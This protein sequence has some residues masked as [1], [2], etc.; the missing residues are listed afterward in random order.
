MADDTIVESESSEE[1]QDESESE[2]EPVES[3]SEEE[4]PVESESEEEPPVESESE[5]EPPAESESE[6]EPPVDEESEEEPPA[7]SESEEEPPVE[8]ESEEEPPVDDLCTGVIPDSCMAF[9]CD[10]ILSI[11]EYTELRVTEHNI[12]RRLHENTPDVSNNLDIACQA[13]V[14]ANHMA[15]NN[16]WGHAPRD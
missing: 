2:E 4:P 13:K 11:H 9:T 12:R 10:E 16:A 14:W 15:V 3:E 1:P 8:E 6:E 7:E 5:E